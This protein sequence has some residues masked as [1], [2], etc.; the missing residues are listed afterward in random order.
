MS[1]LLPAATLWQ[2]EVVRFLRQPNRISGAIG[3][4]LIFWLLLGSGVGESLRAG[5]GAQNEHYLAYAFPGTLVLVLL[6]TAIFSTISIIEDRREGFLQSVLV[7]P[8]PRA[9]IV[10]G[11]ILG[12]SFL[13]LVQALL[14]FAL[15]PLA[16]ISLTWT[17]V[18]TAAGIL[19]LVAFSLTA[20]GFVIA[21]RMQS[22]QGF[23]AIMNFL[24]LPMWVLSGA[25]FPPEGSAVWVQWLVRINPL[26]YGLAAL[27]RVMVP[28]EP[29]VETLPGLGLSLAVC[30]GFA[31]LMWAA[32]TR[33]ARGH[34]VGDL[35]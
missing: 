34:T 7:A 26:A 32:A 9:V 11:K 21:W 14:F 1:F 30:A 10:L 22:I 17:G 2:R 27:R 13:A 29:W 28:G 33:V 35:Q 20:L 16:G 5:A 15:A 24:L 6:F 31:L 4:P 25:L 8:V 19:A 18:L 23:H 3:A 12:G